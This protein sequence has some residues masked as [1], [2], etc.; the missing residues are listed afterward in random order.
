MS[1]PINQ[2]FM[3]VIALNLIVVG[4]FAVVSPLIAIYLKKYD[5][6]QQL[7]RLCVYLA[8]GIMLI[9]IGALLYN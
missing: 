6:K 3:K 1:D 4:A 7:T 8:G 9:I 2:L 5:D